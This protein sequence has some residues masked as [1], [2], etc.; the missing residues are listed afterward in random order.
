M[1]NHR[2]LDLNS[3][4]VIRFCEI[5]SDQKLDIFCQACNSFICTKCSLYGEHKGH[6]CEEVNDYIKKLSTLNSSKKEEVIK[7]FLVSTQEAKKKVT[8]NQA[9]LNKVRSFL[10]VQLNVRLMRR[11]IC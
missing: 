5:H 6:L 10:S 7:K 8:E 9:M 4:S 1:K 2:K 11:L 3:I